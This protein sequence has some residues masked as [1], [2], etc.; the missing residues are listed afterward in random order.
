[1][2]GSRSTDSVVANREVTYVIGSWAQ[3]SWPQQARVDYISEMMNRRVW[4][5]NTGGRYTDSS[6]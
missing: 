3:I 6:Q 5:Q 1:M 4:N 2:A